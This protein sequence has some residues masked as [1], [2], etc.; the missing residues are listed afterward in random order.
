MAT[1]KDNTH[2]LGQLLLDAPASQPHHAVR[3]DDPR[4]E[5]VADNALFVA[6]VEA[7]L[8]AKASATSV[9]EAIDAAAADATT[10]ADAAESAAIT[11]AATDATS[12]ASAAQ[13]A[14]IAAA[15]TDATTKAAAAQA[16]AV[17]RANHTGTQ[18][19]ATIVNLV[20]DLAAK[21]SLNNAALTGVPTAPT[22]SA[23]TNTTQIA[24][25]AFV[26]AEVAAVVGAAPGLLDTLAE[27]ATQLTSDE[28][29]AAALATTVASKAPLAS[30]M[31][32]VVHGSVAGTARPAGYAVVTWIGSV[33]PTNALDNDIWNDTSE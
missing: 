27:I 21:A 30:A 32:A 5:G 24:S 7:A 15:A 12:K 25:T 26:R 6:E 8:S 20:S 23:G 11:A 14:A 18:A 1:L 29:A 10:K 2:V 19:Q 31:G 16:A 13:A 4:L 33:E 28:S 22:A 17:Q 3:H 9:L